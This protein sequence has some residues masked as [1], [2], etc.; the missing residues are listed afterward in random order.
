L[1]VATVPTTDWA[2]RGHPPHPVFLSCHIEDS[3]GNPETQWGVE[4]GPGEP[5]AFTAEEEMKRSCETVMYWRGHQ[6]TDGVT[7]TKY[8]NITPVT[9]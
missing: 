9:F 6:Q 5:V 8:H 2:E 7:K 1:D 3:Y 4:D